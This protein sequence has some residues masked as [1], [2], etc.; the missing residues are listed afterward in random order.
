MFPLLIHFLI[1]ISG[2]PP[3]I[4]PEVI[5]EEGY[6]KPIDWW[7]TGLILYDFMV[8]THPF[9]GWSTIEIFCQVLTS[10]NL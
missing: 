6:G 7:A 9:C 1:Q 8:G 5:L 2:T 10:K 4:A 3:F